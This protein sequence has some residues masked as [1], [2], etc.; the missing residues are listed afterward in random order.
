MEGGQ[1]GGAWEGEQGLWSGEQR[2]VEGGAGLEGG[3]GRGSK[4]L[5][6]G[7]WVGGGPLE[8]GQGAVEGE[9]GGGGLSRESR[10]CGG[11]AGV[12]VRTNVA[13]AVRHSHI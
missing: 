4:G 6:R 11:G 7:T 1:G 12:V 10:G 2:A 3:L 8:G 13:P 5:W 9:A